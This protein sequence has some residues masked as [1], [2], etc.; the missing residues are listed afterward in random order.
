MSGPTAAQTN[1]TNEETAAYTQAQQMTAQQYANQQAIYAPMTAQFQSIFAKGPNQQGYSPEELENLNSQAVEGTAENY[2]GAAKAVNEKLAAEGGGSN[3][4]PSG[5]DA[6]LQEQVATGAAGEESKEE[7]G[8]LS[9]DYATGRS[10][11]ESAWQ[12]LESIAAGLNPIGYENA[13][14]SAGGT[15]NTEANA[16]AAEQDSWET[17]AIGAAGTIGGA[18]AGDF[19]FPSKPAPAAP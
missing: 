16:V 6:Q 7:T 11:Y 15:A 12:G 9:A 8:I 14:T 19:S 18:F 10:E 13:E 3:P 17:A 1:L 4:L 2:Q 5:A